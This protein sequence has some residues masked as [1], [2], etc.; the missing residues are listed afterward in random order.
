MIIIDLGAVGR[1]NSKKSFTQFPPLCILQTVVL[2]HNQI[3]TDAI[4]QSLSE[5]PGFICTHL[6]VCM[7][8]LYVYVVCVYV[9]VCVC[10]CMWGVC[11][12]VFASLQLY[13]TSR[14]IATSMVKIQSNS[15]TT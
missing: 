2:Y 11:V 14:F 12:C 10:V 7:C 1:N 5:C 4:H 8:V 3:D 9:G 6:Y 15:L 13:H